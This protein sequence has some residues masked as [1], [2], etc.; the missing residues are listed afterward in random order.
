MLIAQSA[1]QREQLARAYRQIMK[2][3]WFVESGV[4]II[5]IFRNH[6]IITAGLLALLL[7][8]MKLATRSSFGLLK[9]VLR[10]PVTV[11]VL[12][13]LFVASRSQAG[14]SKAWNV[15]RPFGVW[16]GERFK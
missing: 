10:H 1:A 11:A 12:A 2:P 16:L 5:E 8:P 13:A 9:F 3:V 4:G 6:P 15:L 14:P 7:K